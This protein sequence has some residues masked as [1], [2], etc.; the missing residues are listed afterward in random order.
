MQ[1]LGQVA[2]K[3]RQQKVKLVPLA[4]RGFETWE[5]RMFLQFLGDADTWCQDREM[6]EGQ[7]VS[8]GLP[9]FGGFVFV[10]GVSFW[11]VGWL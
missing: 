5:T 10:V 8:A 2:G 6:Q 1:T 11:L 9:C 4:E 3:S 7:G